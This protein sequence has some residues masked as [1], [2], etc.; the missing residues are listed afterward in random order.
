MAVGRSDSRGEGGGGEG[1]RTGGK[2]KRM[3]GGA[4]GRFQREIATAFYC[5]DSNCSSGFRSKI[6]FSI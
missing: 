2:K 3:G 5:R 6:V 4:K 1:E